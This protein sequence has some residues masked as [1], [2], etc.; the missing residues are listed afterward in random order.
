MLEK[1]NIFY[2]GKLVK[3]LLHKVTDAMA[4]DFIGNY[5]FLVEDLEKIY[6][7]TRNFLR[8]YD[9][10]WINKIPTEY[11]ELVFVAM[12]NAIKE[13]SANEDTFWEHIYK[14]L[15]GTSA[16]QKIYSYLTNV[17]ERLG[18]NKKIIYLSGCTKRYYATIL[19][20]AFAP[21][22]STES[23]LELCWNWY[24]ED[25]N[26]TY[27]K[28]DEIFTLLAKE[29]RHTFTKERSLEDDI[30]LGSEVY[31]LKAGIKRMA[32]DSPEKIIQH[33]E[34]TISLFDRVFSGEILDTEYYYNSIIR[35][36][37]IEKEKSFGISKPKKKVAARA[38][39]D[40]STIR[41]KYNYNGKQ[42]VLTVPSIRLKSNFYDKPI[43]NIYRNEELIDQRDIP[44]FGSGL[45]M[46]TKE[47]NLY[48]DNLVSING[49]IDCS[50]EI[51]HCD[52]IIYNSKNIC[53]EIIYFFEIA[54]KSCRKNVY[55]ETI[56]CLH[57]ILILFLL[58]PI[59]LRKCHLNL[60]CIL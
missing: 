5:V 38:I 34:N 17:I 58:I 45:T 6:D 60:I 1:G 51:V 29:L 32:I 19:M 55:L 8:R 54:E 39:T 43:L 37:W 31:S 40:Y 4:E 27:N 12:V 7:F 41:P 48:V 28:N 52:E 36:W 15:I 50:I 53:S 23:F 14:K 9:K 30:V 2:G 24:S 18:N 47:F 22:N 11:D 33:I 25:M 42:A 46:A 20:H 49:T 3:L 56:F 35:N 16:S 21:L 13:W 26:F 59:V 10:K 44:T 57:P